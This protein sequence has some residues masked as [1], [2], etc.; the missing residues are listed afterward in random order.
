MYSRPEV[1]STSE[2]SLIVFIDNWALHQ[3]LAKKPIKK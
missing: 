3:K 1:S 2:E